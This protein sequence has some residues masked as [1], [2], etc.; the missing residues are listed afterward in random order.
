MSVHAECCVHLA[1]IG[2]NIFWHIAFNRADAFQDRWH[3][4]GFFTQLDNITHF[5]DNRADITALAIQQHMTVI[6]DLAGGKY[7]WRQL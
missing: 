1:V 6:N 7:G 4:L 2:F 5:N 3:L